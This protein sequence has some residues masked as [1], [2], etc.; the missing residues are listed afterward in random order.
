MAAAI[1][2][3]LATPTNSRDVAQSVADSILPILDTLRDEDI[4]HYFDSAVLPQLDKLDVADI[5]GKLLGALMERNL[6]QTLLERM[7][8]LLQELLDN[9]RHITKIKFGERSRLTSR[10]FDS[11]IV[12]TLM[13]GMISVISDIASDPQHDLRRRFDQ[14][15]REF[16]CRLETSSEYR[17]QCRIVQGELLDCLK[18]KT[19]L[20]KLWNDVKL[21]ISEDL[22]R[23]RSVIR[24]HIAGILVTLGKG[25]QEAPVLQV[26]I[27]T[28]MSNAIE[29]LMLRHRHRI[30]GLIADVI[31]SWDA[32]EVAEKVEL[33][34]G[35]DLQYIRINGTLVGGLVGVGLHALVTLI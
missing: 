28:W 22:G 15:V 31:E 10:V 25:I 20:S 7:L 16:I 12:D 33:Q 1:A 4:R 13:D 32:R 24:D 27:N 3:W 34:I 14:R 35:R 23:E 21:R 18:E 11:Y 29:E 9:S 8:P 5:A 30:A 26:N 2:E 19:N 17:E 6:H